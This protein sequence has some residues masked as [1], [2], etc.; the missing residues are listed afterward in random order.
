MVI[1]QFII[2]LSLTLNSL[3]ELV[4]SQLDHFQALQSFHFSIDFTIKLIQI[5]NFFIY[6]FCEDRYIFVTRVSLQSTILQ[7]NGKFDLLILKL[8]DLLHQMGSVNLLLSSVYSTFFQC[9]LTF[10]D[11]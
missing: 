8:L 9:I 6:L 2:K 10:S 11:I 4:R 1:C 5:V 3:T 7:L